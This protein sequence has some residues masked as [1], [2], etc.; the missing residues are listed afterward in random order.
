M[1]SQTLTSEHYAGLEGGG[2]CSRARW[3]LACA[4][5][6]GRASR[7]CRPWKEDFANMFEIAAAQGD[8][9]IVKWLYE[10]GADWHTLWEISESDGY[11]EK[12]MLY[13]HCT[14]KALDQQ[15]H[16]GI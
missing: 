6:D 3:S 16:T 10:R 13:E 1:H 2:P 11:I 8:I 5:L 14:T 12:S 4:S 15:L 9:D 7:R